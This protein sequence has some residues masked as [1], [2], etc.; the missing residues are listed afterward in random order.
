MNSEPAPEALTVM[1]AGL[2]RSAQSSVTSASASGIADP[3]PGSSAPTEKVPFSRRSGVPSGCPTTVALTRP[4]EP[5]VSNAGGL[6]SLGCA[7]LS[8][9]QLR[10]AVTGLRGATDGPFNLNF[11]IQEAPRTE[12]AALQATRQRLAPWYSAA[13]LGAPPESLPELGPCFDDARLALLLEIRPAV[14]SFHFGLPAPDAILALKDAGIVLI[15]TATTVAEARVLE[16]AGVDAV[17]AQG[18]EAGGH[19]GAHQPT[20]PGDGV[21]SLALIPQVVDAV[22]VPVIAAGGIGDGRGIAA[23]FALGASGVQMGT[24]FLSCP[25]AGTDAP[26][27]A[28]L[29]HATDTDTMVT[30]AFSGLSARAMRSRYAEALDEHREPLP[31]F[32]QMYALTDPLVAAGPEDEVSFHLYGQTAALNRELAAPDLMGKLTR[33]AAEAFARLTRFRT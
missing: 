20:A 24:A 11:F 16:R 1:V 26:R 29:R 12:P 27:R 3:A 5:A 31:A 33:E 7:E 19:R 23:A 28:R 14:V 21:G 13:G 9:E 8:L 15:A 32:R 10:A 22:G 6:G 17:I 25:E 2:A 4:P 30:D 18:Y